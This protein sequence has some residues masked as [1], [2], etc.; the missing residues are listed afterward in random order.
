MEQARGRNMDAFERSIDLL[1]S[2]L[3]QKLVHESL[4]APLIKTVR[5]AGYMLTAQT[6]QGRMAWPQRA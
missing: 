6:V 5:G 3:R 1:V 4:E 2:R